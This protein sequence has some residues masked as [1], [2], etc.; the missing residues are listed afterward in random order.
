MSSQDL[1]VFCT[2]PQATKAK[3]GLN[4]S[5]IVQE[6]KKRGLSTTGDRSVVAARLCE[7][8][9]KHRSP[10]KPIPESLIPPTSL[11]PPKDPF[12]SIVKGKGEGDY[13]SNIKDQFKIIAKYDPKRR[14]IKLSGRGLRAFSEFVKSGIEHGGMIDINKDGSLERAIFGIGTQ[15]YIKIHDMFDFEIIFHTHPAGIVSRISYMFELPSIGDLH[16]TMYAM[17]LGSGHKKKKDTN[18]FQVHVVFTAEAVYTIYI[19][20]KEVDYNNPSI[21]K[22]I[23]DEFDSHINQRAHLHPRDLFGSSTLVKL[24]KMMH[25]VSKYGVYIFRYSKNNYTSYLTDEDPEPINNW[26]KYIP[27]YIDPQEP[28]LT[29]NLRGVRNSQTEE[30]KEIRYKTQALQRAQ[31]A[32]NKELVKRARNL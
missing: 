18:P 10:V 2:N 32:Q 25:S 30:K 21:I 11:I 7:D 1:T 22:T 12:E 31:I 29:F 4:L 5:D 19:P 28:A 27:L 14:I 23:I 3:G 15:S 13:V 17:S 9:A 8:I 26:P 24:N 16:A 6:L 20:S